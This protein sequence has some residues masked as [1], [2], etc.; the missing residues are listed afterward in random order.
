MIHVKNNM[1]TYNV[2]PTSEYWDGNIKNLQYLL[3]KIYIT[4]FN[5]SW[6]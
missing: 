5:K 3:I 1:R 2:T 4:R 6:I